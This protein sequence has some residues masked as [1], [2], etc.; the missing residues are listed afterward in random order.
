MSSEQQRPAQVRQVD[1][2]LRSAA[3][4]SSGDAVF[5]A[6]AQLGALAAEHSRAKAAD[7][8]DARNAAARARYARRKAAGTLPP[9]GK[10]RQDAVASAHV[11]RDDLVEEYEHECAC[12]NP[13]VAA[14]CWHCTDCPY[15]WGDA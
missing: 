5:A 2:S 6:L 3:A 13:G 4:G 7:R 11:E 14:P 8:R 15:C 12:A 10:A 1:S 9:R